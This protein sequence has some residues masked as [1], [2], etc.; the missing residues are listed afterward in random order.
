VAKPIGP[1]LPKL[2]KPVRPDIMIRED[3]HNQLLDMFVRFEE[4]KC[5]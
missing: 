4:W 5:Q 2:D 3:L 1:E